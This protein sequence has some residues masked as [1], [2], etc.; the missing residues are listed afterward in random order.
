MSPIAGNLNGVFNSLLS[1]TSHIT[2][3]RQ[4]WEFMAALS[5]ICSMLGLIL[6]CLDTLEKKKEG[7][8]F[9]VKL[10][11]VTGII[12]LAFDL[13]YGGI[14]IAED[15]MPLSKEFLALR[16]FKVLFAVCVFSILF[17]LVWFI[18]QNLSI[19]L[20]AVFGT[21]FISSMVLY[22]F[23]LEQNKWINYESSERTTSQPPFI[24]IILDEMIGVEGI[25][26]GIPGGE[27][28]YQLVRKFHERFKFRLYG[29]AFSRH[30]WTGMSVPNMMNYDYTDTTYGTQS[31][32]F[33]AEKWAFFKDMQN[34]GYRINVYQT[35]HLDFCVADIVNQCNTLNSF[36][37]ASIYFSP[38]EDYSSRL[39]PIR[40]IILR[41][42]LQKV[43]GSYL[44]R[45][46]NRIIK[47]IDDDVF[48][49]ERFDVQSFD[50][51]FNKFQKDVTQTQGGEV[52]F[53]HFLVPHDP[54]LLNNHCKT[55]PIS[56]QEP[57]LLKEAQNLVGEK[58]EEARSFYY[59]FYFEQVSCVYKKLT[60]FMEKI[61]N[62]EQFKNAT[63]VIH[64]D[65]GSRISSGQFMEIL[66]DRDFV[67]NYSTLFSIRS[68]EVKP[69]Y[70]MEFVSIQRLFA[71]I[72]DDDY[73]E[74]SPL[75]RDTVAVDSTEKG[76]VISAIMPDYGMPSPKPA[77]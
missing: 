13:S 36:N 37:P 29:K 21:F 64:G 15:L 68:P 20:T 63:I 49:A 41:V 6:V 65:H 74:T 52:Y 62:L 22:F 57:H 39:L 48:L 59:K 44:A 25:D 23:P 24:H 53:S 70:D 3:G 50:L 42:F 14:Q 35:P 51:W 67:D 18:R 38:P 12:F 73:N 60:G 28:T 19:L 46:I 31:K 56:W 58:F 30:F 54:Y 10:L 9:L 77:E 45:I 61:E 11:M 66:S 75:E 17:I 40:K 7:R 2:S 72:F 1:D 27:E 4:V 5:V 47:R 76:R 8:F 34:R 43:S 33:S 55:Q 26:R 69:G 32:Y 16:V 71:K